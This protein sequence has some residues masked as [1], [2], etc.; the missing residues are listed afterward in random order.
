[1]VTSTRPNQLWLTGHAIALRVPIT[2]N[3]RVFVDDGVELHGDTPR[4]IDVFELR[5]V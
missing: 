1:M 2:G 3:R 4:A 5:A